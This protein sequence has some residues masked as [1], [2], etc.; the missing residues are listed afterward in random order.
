MFLA[1]EH[2]S[3]VDLDL[4]LKVQSRHSLSSLVR[5]FHARCSHPFP[6]P[7]AADDDSQSENGWDGKIKSR[8]MPDKPKG[9]GEAQ[10]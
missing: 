8:E 6:G 4:A 3:R 2:G 10:F 1:A 5:I 7:P 9:A